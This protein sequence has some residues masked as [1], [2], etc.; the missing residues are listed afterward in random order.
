MTLYEFN[1][2]DENAK[3]NH[4]WQHCNY[5][6]NMLADKSTLMLYGSRGAQNFFVEIEL[7]ENKIIKI[8]SFIN[9]KE[10]DKYINCIDLFKM[11]NQ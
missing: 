2:L 6:G 9:G 10:L 8:S 4:V 7:K 1:A 3:A 5:I 11:L